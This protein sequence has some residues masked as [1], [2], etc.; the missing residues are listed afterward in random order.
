MRTGRGGQRIA[1]GLFSRRLMRAAA[2]K[3]DKNNRAD[4]RNDNRTDAAELIGKESEHRLSAWRPPCTVPTRYYL[5]NFGVALTCSR[6]EERRGARWEWECRE[7]IEARSPS[8]PV[9]SYE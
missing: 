5:L 8:R 6:A 2:Q 4:D 3:S 7:A 1:V 9:H